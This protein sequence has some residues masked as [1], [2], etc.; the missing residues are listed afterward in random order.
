MIEARVKTGFWARALLRRI[1]A[2]GRS[3]MVLH[4]GDEDAGAVLITLMDRKGGFAILRESSANQ[5]WER[6]T[7]ADAAASDAYIARQRNYDPDLWVLELET[8]SVEEPV[9][10]TLGTRRDQGAA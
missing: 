6:V 5:G 7:L 2:T 10:K 1:A 4:R 8:D 9:E 3:A